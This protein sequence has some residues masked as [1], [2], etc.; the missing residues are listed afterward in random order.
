MSRARANIARNLRFT[1]WLAGVLAAAC[2]WPGPGATEPAEADPV[3]ARVGQRPILRSD[4]TRARAQQK[5]F[6]RLAARDAS[7]APER[8]DDDT[9]QKNA[10]ANAE[11]KAAPAAPGTQAP[12]A[13][14]ATSASDDPNGQE[15][16]L[17][18]AVLQQLIDQ[19]L[20]HQAAQADHAAVLA[21]EVDAAWSA[22][23]R[24]WPEGELQ[25]ALR[26]LRVTVPEMKAQLRARL[27]A[28][29]VLRAEALARVVVRDE[30]IDGYL[31]AH[32]ALQRAPEAVQLRQIV[33]PDEERVQEV[34]QALKRHAA[35]AD[36]A[37]RL[38][39]APEAAAGGE[40]G[41]LTRDE[42]P[43]ALAE[44]CFALKPRQVSRPVRAADGWHL[45]W[46]EERLPARARPKAELRLYVERQLRAEG[47]AEAAATYLARAA[48]E[49]HVEVDVERLSQSVQ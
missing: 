13:K 21:D 39:V 11:A 48:R 15:L 20:L 40:L 16:R 32:P 14:P 28:G 25:T 10:P 4:V 43:R 42:L 47:E 30:D 45:F 23:A 9:D 26:D 17:R 1:L 8:G 35:F 27:L 24:A 33:V 41:I 34:Q 7:L 12:E 5:F 46:V 29:K 31:A 22:A 36:V 18:R 44:I 37:A 49:A 19:A 6:A 38:S 2:S 3:V